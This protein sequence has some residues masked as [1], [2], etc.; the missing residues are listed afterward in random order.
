MAIN[1]TP[2]TLPHAGIDHVDITIEETYDVEGIGKDTVTLKGR[3][4][5]NRTVPLLGAGT[6]QAT[7]DTATVVAQFTDLNVSGHSKVFGPVHV[8]LDK[9][10]PAFGVVTAGKCLAAIAVH[11][12]MPQHGLTLR[13]AT[14]IQ[15]H[16]TVNTVPPIGD[17]KTE[18]VAGVELIDH[19]TGRRRGALDHARV[20]WRELVEQTR[21][22]VA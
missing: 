14:P 20:A 13:S 5:A 4:T 3:L 11:V 16:S 19:A 15:L 7:W 9:S 6:R 12:G 8:T 1:V 17:E 21:H 10:V 22:N 18:S 2:K